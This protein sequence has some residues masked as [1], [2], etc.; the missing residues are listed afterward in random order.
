MASVFP[1]PIPCESLL[2][3]GKETHEAALVVAVF[4]R[5]P[6][7]GFGRRVTRFCNVQAS[8]LG[9]VAVLTWE[10][11]ADCDTNRFNVCPSLMPVSCG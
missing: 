10:R 1:A 4:L 11:D 3:K 2:V 8:A 5:L 9:L 6:L 7:T